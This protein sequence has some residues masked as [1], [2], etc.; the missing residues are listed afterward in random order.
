MPILMENIIKIFE[1]K[2]KEKGLT[3]NLQLDKSLPSIYAD[4][5]QIEQ[6][7]INLVDNA[8]KYSEKGEIKISAQ[9]KNGTVTI[10]IRDEGV[11]ISDEHIPRIFERFYVV[12]KA[13]SRKSGG[14]GLGLSIVKHIVLLHKGTID[15]ESKVDE[16][17][18]FTIILP[19]KPE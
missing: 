6:M 1:D 12:N 4:P 13:R 3:L 2:L 19:V 16:G 17:T 18:K 15:V 9:P 11:G 10:E 8:I 5:F 7:L 14:T